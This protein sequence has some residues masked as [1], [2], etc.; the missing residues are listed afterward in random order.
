MNPLSSNYLKYVG[1]AAN[2]KQA[3]SGK[4]VYKTLKTSKP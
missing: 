1:I 2:P 3:R 4:D